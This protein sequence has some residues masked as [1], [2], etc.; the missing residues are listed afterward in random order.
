MIETLL[1]IAAILFSFYIFTKSSAEKRL[2]K[3]RKEDRD[4]LV[5]RMLDDYR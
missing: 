5:Q 2:E 4:E 3:Q 1:F